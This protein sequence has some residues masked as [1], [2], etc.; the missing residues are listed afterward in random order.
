MATHRIFTYGTLKKGDYNHYLLKN[1]DYLGEATTDPQ[2]TMLHLGGFPGIVGKGNTPIHG[3]VYEVDEP[4]L[5]RLDRLEGHPDFYERVPLKVNI[6]EGATLEVEGYILPEKWLDN[7][8]P[9][10]ETGDWTL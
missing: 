7:T 2:F 1:A 6:A 5:K 8:R 10:I 4:T 3:E 9:I